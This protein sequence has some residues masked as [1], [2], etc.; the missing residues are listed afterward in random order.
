MRKF[1]CE[2]CESVFYSSIERK[3]CPNIA[4]KGKLKEVSMTEKKDAPD[5]LEDDHDAKIQLQYIA[6]PKENQIP[7]EILR[8]LAAMQK[9]FR[10]LYSEYKLCGIGYSTGVHL[11]SE[12]L[13]DTFA[14]YERSDFDHLDY[15]EKLETTA[16][17][18]K[19]FC[20]R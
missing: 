3:T 5:I 9:R 12:A 1:I 4:C 14:D 13:L 2:E 19:F 16:Y 8:E 10:E 18:I 15:T 17:G 7:D 6:E 20:I 11:T